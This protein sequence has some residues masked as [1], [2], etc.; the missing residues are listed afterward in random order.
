VCR[1]CGVAKR[2]FGRSIAKP[3][4]ASGQQ[5]AKPARRSADEA[6]PTPRRAVQRVASTKDGGGQIGTRVRGELVFLSIKGS[7]CVPVRRALETD[8]ASLATACRLRAPATRPGR[9]AAP[10]PGL[11]HADRFRFDR[12]IV[13]WHARWRLD[14]KGLGPAAAQIALAAATGL[15][16]P[17]GAS[18]PS[19]SPQLPMTTTVRGR[20]GPRRMGSPKRASATRKR[21]GSKRGLD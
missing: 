2:R 11:R 3:L 17:T 13:R 16:A 21:A 12:A 6:R 10:G 20:A 7:A 8:S 5:P 14:A 18:P 1:S 19:C 9:R 4:R 15:A